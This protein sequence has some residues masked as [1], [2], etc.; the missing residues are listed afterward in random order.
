MSDVLLPSTQ[1]F[2]I[3]FVNGKKYELHAKDIQPEST[4]LHFLR[5]CQCRIHACEM[6]RRVP[7]LMSCVLSAADLSHLYF[8]PPAA[9]HLSGTKLVC[10]EGGCGACT[11]LVSKLDH[12]TGKVNHLSVNACLYPLG[13]IDGAHVITVEGIGSPSIGLHPIQIRLAELNGS[14]CGFCTPGIVMAFY[15]L[16]RNNPSPTSAQ[17]EHVL[18]GNLCR[19]TGYR[20][21]LDATK[22]FASDREQPCGMGANCCRNKKTKEVKDDCQPDTPACDGMKLTRT[23]TCSK[24]ASLSSVTPGSPL[25]DAFREDSALIF[26]P[27]LRKYKPSERIVLQKENVTWT[28]PKDLEDLLQLKSA[29]PDAKIICGNSEAGI[30]M[31]F[32][33]DS[34]PWVQMVYISEV[35]E[36]KVIKETSE[37]VEFG[38]SVTINNLQAHLQRDLSA[39]DTPSQHLAKAILSQIHWFA[40]TQIRNVATLAGNICTASP[41]SDLN[42]VW[43]AA[44][45]VH[46]TVASHGAKEG[47]RVDGAKFFTGYRKTAMTPQEVLVSLFV[48][49]RKAND[50]ASSSAAA[51][52]TVGPLYTHAY[53]QSRR[54]AD[55]IAIVTS[56]QQMQLK[57]DDQGTLVFAAVSLSYGGMAPATALAVHTA[58]YLIG[59]PAT[60]ATIHAATPY[61]KQ[62]FP[63]LDAKVLPGGMAEYRLVLAASFLLKMYYFVWSQSTS[64]SPLDSIG[65]L[66]PPFP[67]EILSATEEP[68][69]PVSSG[70]QTYRVRET[71]FAPESAAH[72]AGGEEKADDGGHA[73]GAGRMVLNKVAD[74]NLVGDPS[75]H[76]PAKSGE[77]LRHLSALKQASGAAKFLDDMP[78][79][80]GEVFCGLVLSSEPH[81]KIVSLDASAALAHPGCLGFWSAK[82]VP[83]SNEIGDIIRDE[84]L[85]ASE[86][87]VCVGTIIGVVTGRTQIEAWQIAKLVKVT[88]E[89]LT[90]ILTIDE[91]IAAGSYIAPWAEGHTLVSGDAEA[92]FASTPAELQ[93][94]GEARIGG[95]E[96]FYL[97]TMATIVTPGEDDEMHVIGTTQNPS[98]TQQY[99]ARVLGIGAHKV[100]ATVKRM[101]GGFGG[102]ETRCLHLQAACAV[103]AR[104]TNRP[105]RL[106]LERDTDMSLTGQRHAFVGKY[107]VA[108]SPEGKI[109]A[110]KCDL[111]A[112]AG[113]SADLTMPVVDRALFHIANSYNFGACHFTGRPCKTNLPS[114]T[115]FRGFGGPQGM[116]VGECIMDAVARQL[117]LAPETVRA[118]NLAQ[119]GDFTPYKQELKEHTVPAQWDHLVSE[120]DLPRKRAEIA[121][122]NRANKHRKRGLSILPTCFGISFT[123]KFLNQAGALVLV[124]QDG[125]VLVNH[126]GVEMGQG[127]NTKMCQ[128]AAHAFNIPL[129]KVS[130]SDTATDK[131]AN[132]SPTAASAASDLNGAA[133]LD[134]CNQIL[135]RLEPLRQA[136]PK[137]TWT[138]LVSMAYFERIGLGATGFYATPNVGYDFVKHEGTP[139]N[140]QL[141]HNSVGLRFLQRFV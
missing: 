25:P 128:V 130:L 74:R 10:G 131:V 61:L 96:H 68:D 57:V 62:D 64:V 83:G 65:K 6:Q 52:S 109:L 53:K 133:V 104:K 140:C 40:G 3:C 51:A 122:F 95:Q 55:D 59:K 12:A 129:S 107:K 45:G 124:Y 102:K 85:F 26:P 105:V 92:I 5:T 94:S 134:A 120:I 21:I 9:C 24:I 43:Q 14:Q 99:V 90:P 56:C 141:V 119:Q 4:L 78:L 103:A 49:L 28:K 31:K 42:P 34:K 82:D 13:A 84:E 75:E 44:A 79:A 1:D 7:W 18:D 32:R 47:R 70:T 97:E 111:Y 66:L 50:Q 132:A 60:L 127:L 110:V 29:L 81:A 88:Y 38:A 72:G 113:C 2:M 117:K 19:C 46:L 138:E 48:P 67:K 35:P 20:P 106:V 58:N 11:V 33:F 71:N 16:V 125:T 73:A 8:P 126:G 63:L 76:R 22:S 108:F 36:L 39:Y 89:K 115:A 114:N 101:G 23:C 15:A 123:A 93:L 112:N 17:I 121:E 91:A 100:V 37:G 69:R 98:K 54:R 41:I 118:R 86:T 27:F 135:K 137:K 77:A 87:V 80:H 116:F 139:F 30:D 136:H